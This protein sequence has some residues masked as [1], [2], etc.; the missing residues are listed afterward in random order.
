M[1]AVAYILRM[2]RDV[3][4]YQAN[5]FLTDAESI[6]LSKTNKHIKRNIQI[7]Y[8]IK[9][10]VDAAQYIQKGLGPLKEIPRDSNM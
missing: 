9:Q 10:E 3:L 4:L 5:S 8:N 7:G 2:S 1:A 6:H